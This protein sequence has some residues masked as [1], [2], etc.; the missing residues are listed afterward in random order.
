M[1][2]LDN[3]ATTYPKS[4][5]VYKTIENIS[6]SSCVNAG[7]GAYSQAREA[8][9]LIQE[10]RELLLN[11]TNSNSVAEAVFSASATVACNTILG[12]MPFRKEDVVYVSPFEHNAIMRTVAYF[13][14]KVGFS[15]VE[16]PL[17]K[18]GLEIDLEK[19]QDMFLENKPSY[20]CV[21]YLSNVTGYHLPVEEICNY[22]KVYYAICIVD[23]AQALG[24][25]PIDFSRLNADF[26]VFAG[27]KSL[28]GTFG[29][30]GFLMKK[31]VEL[32]PYLVGG[33]GSDSLNLKMPTQGSERYEA[34]SPNI[35]AIGALKASI[36]ELL[37]ERIGEVEKRLS[38]TLITL[39]EEI[40]EVR[41]YAPCN[42]DRHIGI[43]S[44]NIKGY[45]AA[46]VGLILDEDYKIALRTGYHCAPLI[47]KHLEDFT[48]EGCIRASFGRF[49]T[50]EDV[51]RLACG[52]KEL[53]E[54]LW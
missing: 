40:P 14:E 9:Q 50:I 53:V 52:V 47:H 25:L 6:R 26:L 5:K 21:T 13:A 18:E 10:T 41:V 32:E 43:V 19:L 3:A 44:F 24:L 4:E 7:R 48:H 2:Y 28:Y 34:G 30:G 35:I 16:I 45:I 38:K 36:E 37:N 42:R 8:S 1:I 33:T 39:L 29:V 15:I 49:N 31:G 22:A 11:F 54:E 23:A 17:I 20:V 46:D 12:G 51:Q 27:H